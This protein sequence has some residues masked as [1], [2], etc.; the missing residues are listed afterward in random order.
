M[1]SNINVVRKQN[2]QIHPSLKFQFDYWLFLA[3]GGLVVL[4]MLMV[5]STTFDYGLRFFDDSTYYIRRQFSALLV[6]SVG[7]V[8]VLQ[9]DYH[10]LRRLSVVFLGATLLALVAIL[11]FGQSILGAQRGLLDGSYQPS[12]VAKLATIIYISH[13]LSTKGERITILTYGLLPFSVITGVVCALI[14]RQPDLSTAILIALVSLTLFFVAGAD[15]RQFGLAGLLGGGVFLFLMLTL[16][17]AAARVDAYTIALRDPSQASWHVQ[18][19]LI[20]LGRGGMFGV[21][22]GESTQKFGPLPMAH[23]DGVF[24]ILG[25]E[26]GLAGSL[27]VIIL[28]ALMVWRGFRAAWLARDMFGFLLALGITAWLGYQSLINIAVITAVIPFTGIPLPF[29][30]YGGSSL[31]ISLIAVGIL[32]NVSR[33]AALDRRTQ[34]RPQPQRPSAPNGP[35]PGT[36]RPSRP[37]VIPTE[38]TTGST[39]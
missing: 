23:T 30:S 25:E 3:V 2:G 4:G 20:A 31:A 38:P 35:R 28:L 17:H 5:Y 10:V 15:W 8:V 11:F 16:P 14:V 39:E 1:M 27:L 37:V 13:W 29:L 7:M 6:G 32:L 26:M 33:D 21:G 22:L 18:Q 19:S 36:Q 12:E 34:Q 24:A 9:F